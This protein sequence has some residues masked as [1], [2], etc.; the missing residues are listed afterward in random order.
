MKMTLILIVHQAALTIRR[1]SC[2]SGLFRC[3]DEEEDETEDASSDVIDAI[4]TLS[5][6]HH[7]QGTVKLMHWDSNNRSN[8]RTLRLRGNSF[9]NIRRLRNRQVLPNHP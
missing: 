5:N 9:R 6:S 3:N 2:G 1:A 7:C 8:W 4:D